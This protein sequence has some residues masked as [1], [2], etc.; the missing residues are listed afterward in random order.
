[1]HAARGEGNLGFL[2]IFLLFSYRFGHDEDTIYS[3]LIY[4]SLMNLTVTIIL[5]IF[6]GSLWLS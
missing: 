2:F 3:L 4:Q 5:T 6:Y 1:M